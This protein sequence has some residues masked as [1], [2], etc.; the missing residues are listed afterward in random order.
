MVNAND[1]THYFDVNTIRAFSIE[2]NRIPFRIL[3]N[4]QIYTHWNDLIGCHNTYLCKIMLVSCNP[5]VCILIVEDGSN[6]Y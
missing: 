5:L 1:G 6:N 4:A 2:Y 3:Q